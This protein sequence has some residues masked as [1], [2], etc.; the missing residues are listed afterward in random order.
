MVRASTA[1]SS[2][3]SAVEAA[4]LLATLAPAWAGVAAGFAYEPI[5]TVYAHSSGCR[6]AEPMLA[7]PADA[8]RPAQFV[9]DRG[10]LGGV[11]G[12]LAFV[13][14][15]AAPWLARG[16]EAIAEATLAQAHEQ[17]AAQ[18]GG[19]LALV[20]TIVEKR[21]TFRCVPG[22]LRPPLAVAPGVV[23]AGD[24]IDGPYPATLE[25]AVRS[26]LAAARAAL[27]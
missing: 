19:P 8:A 16:S 4:R 24:Y 12:Q 21:A 23:A 18:L 14:S 1:W 27:A 3:S 26:G 10:Q 6:L 2:P 20:R 9:F 22:L 13:I 25:G 11:A 7:L 17:L 5:A 15:G